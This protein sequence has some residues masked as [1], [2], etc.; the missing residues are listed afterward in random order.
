MY[1]YI[2]APLIA[3]EDG[4]WQIDTNVYLDQFKALKLCKRMQFYCNQ[5]SNKSSAVV[6]GALFYLNN[7]IK[8]KNRPPLNAAKPQKELYI[9]MH[10]SSI[11][12]AGAG[13][14]STQTKTNCS[15]ETRK[16]KLHC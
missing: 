6:M 8:M 12:S 3:K 2:L 5:P 7:A 16:M 15:A 11:P 9:T 14:F 1:V 10:I 4:V 13:T